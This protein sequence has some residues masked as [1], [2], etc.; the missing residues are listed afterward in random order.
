[1]ATSSLGIPRGEVQSLVKL[2]T[3]NALLNRQLSTICQVNG[4]RSTGVKAELQKRIV[5]CK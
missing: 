2:V 5:T 1:M 3:S 4:L